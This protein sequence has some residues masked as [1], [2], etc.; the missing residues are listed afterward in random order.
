MGK[1]ETSIFSN[2]YTIIGTNF[3]GIFFFCTFLPDI[4]LKVILSKTSFLTWLSFSIYFSGKRILQF[5]FCVF[6]GLKIL[7][8][9]RS[10]FK[11]GIEIT[12]DM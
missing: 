6:L 9:I 3:K 5:F 10:Y 4:T 2:K 11:G 8:L 7:F 12:F 1:T